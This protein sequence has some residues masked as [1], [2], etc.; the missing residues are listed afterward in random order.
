MRLPSSLPNQSGCQIQLLSVAPIGELCYSCLRDKVDE[1]LLGRIDVVVWG[2]GGQKRGVSKV[3]VASCEA[4]AHR[5][6]Q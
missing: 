5:Q 6:P 3:G 2:S 1:T 4:E